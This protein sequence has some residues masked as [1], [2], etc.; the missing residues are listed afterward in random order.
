M[1]KSSSPIHA[2]RALAL[3]LSTGAVVPAGMAAPFLLSTVCF[4]QSID[5]AAKLVAALGLDAHYAERVDAVIDETSKLPKLWSGSANA[6]TAE[7]RQKLSRE[8]LLDMKW[9]IL[10]AVSQRLASS[11]S[12]AEL[13]DYLTAIENGSAANHPLAYDVD[14]TFTDVIMD[15][16]I[17]ISPQIDRQVQN[18]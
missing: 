14:F 16:L 17:R 1:P 9:Q 6:D 2:S 18:R 3:A 5:T 12:D 13:Q 8:K 7:L 11:Y 15:A 4:A 10:D